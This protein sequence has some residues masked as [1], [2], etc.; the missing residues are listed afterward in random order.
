MCLEG[1]CQLALSFHLS[2]PRIPS[3]HDQTHS[4]LWSTKEIQY[5]YTS[6]MPTNLIGAH[7]HHHLACAVLPRGHPRLALMWLSH[8][9]QADMVSASGSH[10]CTQLSLLGA[11]LHPSARTTQSEHHYL[12][13]GS[14]SRLL[15]LQIQALGALEGATC[16][17]QPSI[18]QSGSRLIG[19]LAMNTSPRSP[20][21]SLCGCQRRGN[22]KG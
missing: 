3:G 17:A 22:S 6:S 10:I 7:V 11:P 5:S 14:V 16:P 9:L 4:R 15:T 19:M 13:E 20:G 21:G 2:I 12:V 18:A 1:S 8:Y